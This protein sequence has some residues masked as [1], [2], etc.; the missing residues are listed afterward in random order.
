MS[1]CRGVEKFFTAFDSPRDR[2]GKGRR[3]ELSP[4]D[5]A[6]RTVPFARLRQRPDERVMLSGLFAAALDRTERNF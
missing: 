5:R 2:A 6:S 4:G 1:G 3:F